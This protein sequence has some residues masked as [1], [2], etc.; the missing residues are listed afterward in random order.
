MKYG[1]MGAMPDEVDQLC[2]RLSGVEVQ[3]YAGV[4][5]H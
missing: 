1:I 5:Y 4:E 3:Q 2:A